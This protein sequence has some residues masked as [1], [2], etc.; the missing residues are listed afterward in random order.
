MRL[1]ARSAIVAATLAA[2]LAMAGVSAAQ[3]APEPPNTQPELGEVSRPPDEDPRQVDRPAD[4]NERAPLAEDGP[5]PPR[6]L[7]EALQANIFI[8]ILIGGLILMMVLSSRSKRKQETQRRQMLSSLKK[9][10]KITTIGGIVGTVVELRED[11][12]TVK[13]DDSTRM[14]FA[15]WAVRG[16]GEEAKTQSPEE[17]R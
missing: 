8:V 11:E 17:R 10:D 16:V 12:V 2:L 15:R 13:V 7:W 1:H 14:K 5:P 9:G 6:T 4:A 3:E